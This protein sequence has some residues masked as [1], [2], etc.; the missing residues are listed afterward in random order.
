MR[1]SYQR[2]DAGATMLVVMVVVLVVALWSGGMGHGRGGHGNHMA[3]V[4]SDGATEKKTL[5]ALNAAYARGEI[6]RDEYLLKREE[7][8]KH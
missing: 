5:D 8:L 6:S 4:S 7:L 3:S 1:K 2:G